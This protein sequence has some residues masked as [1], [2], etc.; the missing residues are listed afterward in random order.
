MIL[1]LG[2]KAGREH[3]VQHIES[4]DPNS[5]TGGK[6][7]RERIVQHIESHD[8]NSW[9]GGKA[10]RERISIVGVQYYMLKTLN[11]N[12]I[13]CLIFFYY[14]SVPLGEPTTT[15]EVIDGDH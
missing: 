6:A 10:G 3:I 1:T 13:K 12:S 4:H 11:K 7:E 5:W 8:P 9:T 14:A 15:D 2:G